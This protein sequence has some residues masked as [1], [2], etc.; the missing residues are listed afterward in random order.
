MGCPSLARS[1]IKW[2][3]SIPDL[4]SHSFGG[5]A[6]PANHSYAC[7]VRRV[8]AKRDRAPIQILAMLAS[9]IPRMETI[10]G[11]TTSFEGPEPFTYPRYSLAP[12]GRLVGYSPSITIAGRS[13]CGARRSREMARLS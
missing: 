4:P 5:P 13:T 8:E 11:L 10:S 2:C 3:G 12:D 1:P 6:A 9:S 7:F